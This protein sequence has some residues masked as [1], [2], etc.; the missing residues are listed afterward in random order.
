MHTLTSGAYKHDGGDEPPYI[1]D[2]TSN[3]LKSNAN[4]VTRVRFPSVP[5]GQ[6]GSLMAKPY[7][8]VLMHRRHTQ[9]S[10]EQIEKENVGNLV[11]CPYFK[12]ILK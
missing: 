5:A 11:T 4:G 10:I 6:V 12:N 1:K 7:K 3:Q 2:A 8:R 9:Q